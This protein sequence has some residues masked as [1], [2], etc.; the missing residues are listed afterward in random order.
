MTK[1]DYRKSIDEIIN[2]IDD[3]QILR[4]IYIVV[5]DIQNEQ[6]S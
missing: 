6:K 3:E 2:N 5:K 1:E 4:Y